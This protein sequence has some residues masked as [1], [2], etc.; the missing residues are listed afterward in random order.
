M[1][2]KKGM[3]IVAIHVERASD[4]TVFCCYPKDKCFSDCKNC[5]YFHGKPRK[6]LSVSLDGS[7]ELERVDSCFNRLEPRYLQQF[8]V[9]GGYSW[10]KL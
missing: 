5:E 7:V 3:S 8:R 1:K 9:I 10:R 2:I 4:G 6:I